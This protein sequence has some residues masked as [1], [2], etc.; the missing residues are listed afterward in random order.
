MITKKKIIL[1]ILAAAGGACLIVGLW[2]ISHSLI[3]WEYVNGNIGNRR[4]EL[5]HVWAWGNQKVIAIHTDGPKGTATAVTPSVLL[6]VGKT[7]KLRVVQEDYQVLDEQGNRDPKKPGALVRVTLSNKAGAP[8]VLDFPINARPGEYLRDFKDLDVFLP[9]GTV[10]M[11]ISVLPLIDGNIQP[12]SGTFI[13][14]LLPVNLFRIFG[15]PLERAG[16]ILVFAGIM[17]YAAILLLF[18][19]QSGRLPRWGHVCRLARLRLRLGAVTFLLLFAGAVGSLILITYIPK[20]DIRRHIK[21]GYE[22]GM[23]NVGWSYQRE[24]VEGIDTFSDAAIAN[25][26][27]DQNSNRLLTAL[28]PRYSSPDG[29]PGWY[30]EKD[31]LAWVTDPSQMKPQDATNRYWFGHMVI[32][33]PLL[34]IF[35]IRG[36]R[37]MLFSLIVFGAIASIW[38][39]ERYAK[40]LL[41]ITA[42]L[43]VA[44]FT[45]AGVF[46]FGKL[47][48][49]APA[50]LAPWFVIITSLLCYRHMKPGKYK[51][52]LPIVLGCVS[53][54]MENAN[55]VVLASFSIFIVI[56]YFYHVYECGYKRRDALLGT[57]GRAILFTAAFA[58]FIFFKLVL[59]SA[60]MGWEP[61]FGVF[62]TSVAYRSGV[63]EVINPWMIVELVTVSARSMVFWDSWFT[64][65]IIMSSLAGGVAF[66]AASML[67]LAKDDHADSVAI[68]YLV[69]GMPLAGTACW[70][71]MFANHT[72]VHSQITARLIFLPICFFLVALVRL[73]AL[74]SRRFILKGRE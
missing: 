4:A 11:S 56:D 51:I 13:H 60:L 69:M 65:T 53:N 35:N 58:G 57:L 33:K 15:L 21:Q 47:W 30:P 46:Q 48:V 39:T 52:I 41:P 2:L 70:F 74:S 26:E 18:L 9:D 62:L 50:Y 49:Q 72:I 19:W 55:G 8:N 23:L 31:L 36:V 37:E 6:P 29:R 45:C 61:T 12:N 1:L 40:S 44:I 64:P 3:R 73:A 14:M 67:K 16:G 42:C 25:F 22:Q 71:F 24:V 43:S 34:W 66:L 5:L 38:A 27:L 10:S 20:S 59:L 7:M 63:N 32:S 28:S 54:F 17:A 68:D